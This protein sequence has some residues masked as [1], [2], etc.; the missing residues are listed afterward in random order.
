L[1]FRRSQGKARPQKPRTAG[2]KE[3]A[4]A[5][6]LAAVGHPQH[7]FIASFAS[8]RDIAPSLR[9]SQLRMK[10]FEPRN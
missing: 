1:P 3:T 9:L 4:S 8:L 6:P 5:S 7:F 2:L 10:P